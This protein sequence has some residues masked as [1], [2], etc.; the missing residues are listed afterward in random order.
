[1]CPQRLTCCGTA[2]SILLD[3]AARIIDTQLN[4]KV[5]E[6]RRAPPRQVTTKLAAAGAAGFDAA[7]SFIHRLG[8]FAAQRHSRDRNRGTDN[9][10]DQRIFG[11]RSAA[12]VAKHVN[13][14]DHCPS[15][16]F[17]TAPRPAGTNGGSGAGGGE[18]FQKAWGSPPMRL[19]PLPF[20]PRPPGRM[21]S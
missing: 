9:R 17:S 20:Y 19:P 4:I 18:I 8:N 12:L 16:Y 10:Q 7:G 6:G 11:G 2:A 1:M 13:E 5:A 15:P 3:A 21:T 14:L